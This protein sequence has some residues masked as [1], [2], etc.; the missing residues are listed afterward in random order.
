MEFINAT[1]MAASYNFGLDPSGRDLLVIV[2]KGTFVLPM[3]GGDVR[4]L[5][6]QV[7]LVM[8]DTFTGQPG[9]SAPLHEVDFAPRKGMCDVLLVG[10]ARAPDSRPLQRM[11]V[12]LRVGRLTKAF[13]VVGDRVWL[14]GSAGT[15]ASAPRHFSEMPVSYDVA[16]GGTSTAS[17]DVRQH[18]AFLSNPVG[19]GWGTSRTGESLD[20][21]PLPNTEETGQVVRRASGNYRPMALGPLGRGWSQRVRFAGTYDDGWRRDAFPFLPSDFDELFYQAAPEDQQIPIPSTPLDITLT[22][23]TANGPRHFT[24]P[25]FEAPVHVFPKDGGHARFDAKLDTMVFEPDHDRITLTWRYTHPLRR[26]PHEVAQVLVGRKSEAWW[27]AR[28]SGK[29]YY[30]SLAEAGLAR[31]NDSSPDG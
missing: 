4:L 14:D 29:A 25:S 16:F 24:L 7:P 21:K 3:T 31:S 10:H 5:D 2:V 27:R 19:R 22:G 11:T 30:A 17:D 28:G 8:A 15:S 18:D 13:D 9:T 26:D 23:F 12:G 1:R 6:D 20:G